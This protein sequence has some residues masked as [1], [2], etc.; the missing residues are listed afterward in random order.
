MFIL[1]QFRIN[2]PRYSH[3]KPTT[4]L[5]F[6]QSVFCFFVDPWRCS[7]AAAGLEYRRVHTNT[8]T[9]TLTPQHFTIAVSSN[10]SRAVLKYTEDLRKV[11]FWIQPRKSLRQCWCNTHTH[12]HVHINILTSRLSRPGNTSSMK[13]LSDDAKWHD[14][15]AA[16]QSPDNRRRLQTCVCADRKQNLT[17]SS[18]KTSPAHCSHCTS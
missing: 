14:A 1:H 4:F 9:H 13:H 16:S 3:W 15:L 12:T 6:L 17:H 5:H 10:S 2:A 18:K 7:D 8:Q 11:Y